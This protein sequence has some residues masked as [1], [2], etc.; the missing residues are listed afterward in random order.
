VTGLE[1]REKLV[2]LLARRATLQRQ[3]NG[4]RARA[5]KVEAKL[6]ALDGVIMAVD[7]E[8]DTPT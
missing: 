3:V 1:R 7:A 2:E 4:L 5:A 8:S 6:A